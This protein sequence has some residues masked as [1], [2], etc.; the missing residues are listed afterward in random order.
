MTRR[1][2]DPASSSSIENEDDRYEICN[3]Q[4][5]QAIV[6]LRFVGETSTRLSVEE[7]RAR[8]YQLVRDLDASGLS[9]EPIGDCGPTG[10]CMKALGSIG[11]SGVLDG[12][13]YTIFN[14]YVSSPE[15]GGVGLFGVLAPSG[16]V[17]NLNLQD[18]QIEGRAGVGSVVGSNFGTS[19]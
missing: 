14:L 12:R 17:M 18:V 2:D 13:G 9:F 10:N 16:V 8:S 11:F 3:I 6:T 7:R 4:Q 5:L 15:R 19:L 1:P